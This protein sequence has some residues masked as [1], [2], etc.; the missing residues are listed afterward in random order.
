MG[1][2]QSIFIDGQQLLTHIYCQF[3]IEIFQ[4][5]N[6][7]IAPV[8]RL[9]DWIGWLVLNAI[10]NSISVISW[11]P[12]YLSMFFWSSFNQYSSQCSFN[13][14]LFF[15]IKIVGTKYRGERGVHPVSM[16]IIN[17]RKEYWP[18]RGS[19]QRPVLKSTTYHLKYGAWLLYLGHSRFMAVAK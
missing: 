18:S 10:F 8:L 14:T 3:I 19:N 11:Q 12:V 7:G 17:P 2:V 4:N 9:I 5:G 16:T 13:A 1:T 6:S 15:H